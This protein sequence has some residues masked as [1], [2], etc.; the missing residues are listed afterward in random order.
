MIIDDNHWMTQVSRSECSNYN[1]RPKGSEDISLIVVHCMSLPE[2]VYNT[3]SVELLFANKLD[4]SSHPDFHSLQGLEVSAHALI[5]R[6]GEI[7]QFVPFDARAWHAGQSTFQ[8]RDNCNDF[9]IGIELE[10]VSGG[11]FEQIQYQ[12]LSKVCRLLCRSYTGLNEHAIT[13]HSEVALPQGRKNDPGS[14]FDWHG[15]RLML[16]QT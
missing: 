4:C 10:G 2:G 1:V 15:F 11:V 3:D 14:G 16:Q 5:K 7:V 8:G 6:S 12:Q 13:G 9:S